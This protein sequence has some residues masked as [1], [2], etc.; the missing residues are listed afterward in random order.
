MG[1]N[2][3][4][5]REEVP[6]RPAASPENMRE[7]AKEGREQ[8]AEEGRGDPTTRVRLFIRRIFGR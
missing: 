5:E 1:E 6:G 3:D 4:R 8:R 7:Q 2:P